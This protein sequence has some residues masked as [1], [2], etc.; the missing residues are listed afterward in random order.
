MKTGVIIL[1]HG[2][3]SPEALVTVR[4]IKEMVEEASAFDAVE[5]ASLQF[6][7]P[8]LP[9][10]LADMAARGLQ[11]VVVVPLFLYMGLHMKRDIPEILAE[12]E[13]LYPGME[14]V[15]ARNIG[16]DKKLAEIV[17]DRIRGVI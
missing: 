7:Q 9:A 6:N 5:V 12:Q 13:N 11:K 16:A 3:R 2:S 4:K 14:I 17:L 8:D 1:S 10:T 15:M